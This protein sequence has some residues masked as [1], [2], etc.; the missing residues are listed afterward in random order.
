MTLNLPFSIRPISTDFRVTFFSP[1][2]SD[3]IA[4]SMALSL[5]ILSL[6]SSKKVLVDEFKDNMSKDKAIDLAI[7]SLQ[8]GEKKVTLKSV[9]MGLIENGKF[10][11]MPRNELKEILKKYV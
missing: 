8:T 6:N 10:R 3:F 2:C 7:K 11:V 4:K 5:D 1:V 9:E